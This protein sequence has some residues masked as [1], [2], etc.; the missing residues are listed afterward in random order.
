MKTAFL[1]EH[2]LSKELSELPTV[3]YLDDV[4]LSDGLGSGSISGAVVVACSDMGV[5]LPYACSATQANLFVIQ[6]FGPC[7][8]ENSFA[9]IT[10]SPAVTDV[11]IYGHSNCAFMNFLARSEHS[12]DEKELIARHFQVEHEEQVKYREFYRPDDGAL[13]LMLCR[14]N[15]LNQMKKAL[16]ADKANLRFH[17]WFHNSDNDTLEIFDQ[18]SR[19]FVVAKAERKQKI[20]NK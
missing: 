13:P 4:Q 7:V 17:A 18:A 3:T 15:V 20:S 19:A 14:R 10:A 12:E 9:R 6:T 1:N 8:F 5:K 16:S 11:I 2:D